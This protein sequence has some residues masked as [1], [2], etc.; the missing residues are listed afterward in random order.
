M[1]KKAENYIL[2][3]KQLMDREFELIRKL[4]NLRKEFNISQSELALLVNAT[5][6]Q[7]FRIENKKHSPQLNTLLKILDVF[8]YTIEL[9]KIR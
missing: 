6:P 2:K 5:Q 9:K 1:N 4:M 8:G 7:I 3:E